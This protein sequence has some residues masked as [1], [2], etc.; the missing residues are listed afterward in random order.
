MVYPDLG[1]RFDS[2]WVGMTSH[3][4]HL[5]VLD[6]GLR[7]TVYGGEGSSCFSFYHSACHELASSNPPCGYLDHDDTGLFAPNEE[8]QVVQ[9]F[10]KHP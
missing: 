1:R 4:V 5:L 6:W 10:T 7:D 3:A 2:W 8:K 9:F